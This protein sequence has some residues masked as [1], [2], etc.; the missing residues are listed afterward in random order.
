MPDFKFWAKIESDA[1][2]EITADTREQARVLAEKMDENA[3]EILETRIDV[4]D[5]D[6]E[7]TEPEKATA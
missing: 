7:P 6:P 1:E 5:P 4:F 3:F 2:I